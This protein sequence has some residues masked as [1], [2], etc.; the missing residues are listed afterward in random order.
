MARRR[1]INVSL[2]FC[3]RVINKGEEDNEGFPIILS[4]FSQ[5]PS[6]SIFFLAKM[7]R[8]LLNLRNSQF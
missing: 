8:V 1:V 5:V 7:Q 3:L 4:K 6:S 2:I